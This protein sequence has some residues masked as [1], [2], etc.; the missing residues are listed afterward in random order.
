MWHDT[1]A[2]GS[3]EREVNVCPKASLYHARRPQ[4]RTLIMHH[5]SVLNAVQ[6]VLDLGF[7]SLLHP[8]SAQGMLVSGWCMN[9]SQR[10]GANK[11]PLNPDS[12]CFLQRQPRAVIQRDEYMASEP[13]TRPP[14]TSG[15]VSCWQHGCDGRTFT[16]LRN[17]RR[18]INEKERLTSK[19]CCL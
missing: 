7:S 5:V 1:A 15:H 14:A 12:A 13:P 2:D 17:Y 8:A 6:G 16:S 10:S 4:T 11:W 18:H 9:V 3:S 19:A